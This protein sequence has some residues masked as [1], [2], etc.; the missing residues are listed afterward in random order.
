MLPTNAMT[1]I[2]EPVVND[3]LD[4]KV[5]VRSNFLSHF[6]K[7]DHHEGSSLCSER[8][9]VQITADQLTAGKINITL[10]CYLKNN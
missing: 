10:N 4:V 9:L 5:E 7:N 3:R 1:V 8:V 6:V 2:N